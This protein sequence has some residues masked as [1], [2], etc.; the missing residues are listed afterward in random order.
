MKES[1][2]STN[3]VVPKQKTIEKH[4]YIR[5]FF[6]GIFGFIALNL[7]I[8]SIFVVWLSGTLTNTDQYVKTVTPIVSDKV[9]QDYVVN[10]VSSIILD[11]KDI[12]LDGIAENLLLPEQIEGKTDEELRRLIEP[13]IKDSL[14]Q[15][16]SSPSFKVLWVE[17]N[18]QIHLAFVSG[19]NDPKGEVVIN[20][21]PV[22]D[23]VLD[24]L[25]KTKFNFIQDKMEI[26]EDSAVIKIESSRL[27]K[28]RHVYDYFKKA[29]LALLVCAV[30]AGFISVMLSVHHLKTL[31]RI[32]VFT[33]IF[34]GL[35]AILFR[36]T[37]LLNN[38]NGDVADKALTI[39][40]IDIL[41]RDL[42]LAL[43]IISVVT[44]SVA[45][46]SKIVSVIVK[47]RN[48]K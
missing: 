45:I 47:K 32:A 35:M 25:G 36:S 39:K 21:Q 42:W 10:K 14:M 37:A 40:L 28:A 33:G 9:V 5:T 4:H 8:F 18:R 44:L 1:T 20:T 43:V 22:I 38:L 13:I 31:R 7:I 12:P 16:L 27:D 11:N 34:T 2:P 46:G 17:T 41:V 26:P 48:L 15:V 3:A 29:R 30:F 19:I 23:G 24:E 6:A